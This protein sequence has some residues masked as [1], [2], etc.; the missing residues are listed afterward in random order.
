[1]HVTALVA[2]AMLAVAPLSA[3]KG[4]FRKNLLHLVRA[5]HQ[6]AMGI[7]AH[8]SIR[9]RISMDKNRWASSREYVADLIDDRK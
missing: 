3:D 4:S 8:H 1:M 2:L 7:N 9:R 5:A 6:R